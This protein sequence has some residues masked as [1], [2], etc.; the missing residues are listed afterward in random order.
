MSY[1]FSQYDYWTAPHPITFLGISS[2][3]K[4]IDSSVSGFIGLAPDSGTNIFGSNVNDKDMSFVH[5]LMDIGL[6][7]DTIISFFIDS[8]NGTN[9]IVQFGGINKD[10]A[11]EDLFYYHTNGILDWGLPA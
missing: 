5:Q 11:D 1:S 10:C 4:Q 6:I 8:V 2:T 3:T 9:S 7:S